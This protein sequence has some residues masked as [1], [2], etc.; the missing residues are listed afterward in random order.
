MLHV[1]ATAEIAAANRA[2]VVTITT[3]HS[4]VSAKLLMAELR[5]AVRT[6]CM[7]ISAFSATP[8]GLSA[9]TTVY[10]FVR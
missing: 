10:L 4:A 6:D 7:L 5:S 1:M 2:I 3:D 9:P 8:I